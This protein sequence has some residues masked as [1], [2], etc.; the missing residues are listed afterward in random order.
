MRKIAFVTGIRSEYDILASI[1]KKVKAHPGLE[2]AIIVTGAHLSGQFGNTLREIEKDNFIIA[3]KIET[4]LAGD[5]LLSRAKSAALQY[6]GLVQ[7]FDRIKPDIIMAMGD[8][9]EAINCAMAGVY[10]NV[11]VAHISGGDKVW[12]NVDDTVRHA[13]TKLAH[14]HFPTTEENSERIRKLGE[15]EWRIFCVGSAGLDR[16]VE[17]ENLSK[18]ELSKRIGFSITQEPYLLLIQHPLS[19][20]FEIAEK[21]MRIT[22]EAIAEAKLKTFVSYPNSDAGSFGIIKVLEEFTKKY[23]FINSYRNL[24]RV[25]FVNLLRNSSLLLGNSSC[26]ITEAPLLKLP[27][28]NIGNRQKNRQHAENVIFVEAEKNLI[29]KAINV[30]LKDKKFL[31]KVKNCVN[32]Y[33]DG[34]T[35]SKIAKILSEIELNSKLLNKDITY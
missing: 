6:L 20:E 18:E 29:L 1:I 11:P 8:R 24:G 5:T 22:L 12:G 33:G 30:S 26:G 16:F 31:Q 19:S 34:N 32:P 17:T 27:V 9:E 15:E 4:L 14:L 35:G 7:A 28:I 13:V 23:N 25:E 2:E 21:Q 3:E 10:L